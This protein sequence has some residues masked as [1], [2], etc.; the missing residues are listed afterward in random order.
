MLTLVSGTFIF[1]KLLLNQ[2]N[3]V[4]LFARHDISNLAVSAVNRLKKINN[5]V[6]LAG[7]NRGLLQRIVAVERWMI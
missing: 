5:F 4:L 1:Q 2:I 7:I 3:F 6:P